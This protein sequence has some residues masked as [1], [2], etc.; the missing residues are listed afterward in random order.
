MT[1]G[2]DYWA[3]EVI[4]QSLLGIWFASSH[5][6]WMNLDFILL[7]LCARPDWQAILRLEI[8]QAGDLDYEILEKLPLLDSFMKETIR[9]NPLDNCEYSL[10]LLCYRTF[11]L[12]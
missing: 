3:P 4:S 11:R 10:P 7:E 2:N 6:P 5:Q 1:E 12:I 8:E 9:L